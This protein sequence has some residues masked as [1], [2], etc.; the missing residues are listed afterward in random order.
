VYSSDSWPACASVSAKD[1]SSYTSVL[2][3]HQGKHQQ[4]GSSFFHMFGD[5]G[6]LVGERVDDPIILSP[7]RFS[8]RFIEHR[9]QQRSTH[10]HDDL[11]VTAIRV[12]AQW[13][14][15]RCH[16]APGGRHRSH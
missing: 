11:G 9:V 4:L 15:Q 5:V 1:G 12:V 14:R 10:G 16:D 8:V 7:N 6:E 2:Y 13:V 3:G